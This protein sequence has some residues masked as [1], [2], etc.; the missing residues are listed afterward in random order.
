M[1][2]LKE[3]LGILT[4]VILVISNTIGSGIFLLPRSLAHYGSISIIAWIITSFGA[5]FIA[6]TFAQLNINKKQTVYDFCRNNLGDFTG[7]QA[8]FSYFN[9]LWIGNS[10]IVL[11]LL[12]Y[13]KISF[14]S[15]EVSSIAWLLFGIIILWVITFI[16]IKG[17]IWIS[18]LQKTIFTLQLAPLLMIIFVGMPELNFSNFTNDFNISGETNLSA[19]SSSAMLTLWS[20]IG[21]EAA[22]MLAQKAKYLHNVKKATV[23]GTIVIAI[24]YIMS[25]S[26]I[27]GII[28]PQE[29]VHS[30]TPF[31]D[32]AIRIFGPFGGLVTSICI[33]A[34]CMG[35]LNSA[36]ILQSKI[37]CSST[38]ENIFF[39]P[40][41]ISTKKNYYLF[42]SILPCS[43]S[44]LL[45]IILFLSNK[46]EQ[47]S[48]IIS[49]ATLF[50]LFVYFLIIISELKFLI[51][52]QF[53]EN[54]SSRLTIAL[55][56]FIYVF[57]MLIAINK[58]LLYYGIISWL[59][60]AFFYIFLKKVKK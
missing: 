33:I 20:F 56:A 21:I 18:L 59:I 60:S 16:N 42:A 57:C 45:L 49:L 24:I 51:H 39:M 14:S 3:N 27:M 8:S 28:R 5:M 23:V 38:A 36:I 13:L 40:F 44:S 30:E 25:I 41:K 58:E 34:S 22:I 10:G 43:L 32:V 4:L 19:F 48:M 11:V 46:H 2:N 17:F 6:L 55:L 1:G 37:M 50:A 15:F 54:K 9:S 12:S 31:Y 35:A 52:I 29:L 53:I 26:V 47:V 7:F